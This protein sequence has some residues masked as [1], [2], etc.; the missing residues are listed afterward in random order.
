MTAP[1][2][3]VERF[4][5]P[6]HVGLCN[7]LRRTLLT[8]I[9]TEAPSSVRMITNVTCHTDEYIAHRVGLVPFRR[10]GQGHTLTLHAVGPRS[11]TCGDF[12]GPSFEP[13][14]PNIELVYLDAG[15]ALR[16]EVTF[17]A[18]CAGTH[19]RYSPCYAVG[20]TPARTARGGAHV[21]S[22]GSNDH[23]P[24]DELLRDAFD[25]LSERLDRALL[26]LAD[27]APAPRSYI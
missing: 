23:R 16:M 7:A 11:V 6:G 22:F 5:I 8:D 1:H 18:R 15:H 2:S 13:V 24:P 21:L 12:V 27:D 26:L 20:M 25:L 19:A 4:R 14:H 10:A 3:G 9:K 17:D